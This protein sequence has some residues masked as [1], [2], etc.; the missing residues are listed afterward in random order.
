MNNVEILIP[1]TFF[2]MIGFI[3]WAIARTRQSRHAAEMQAQFHQKMLDRFSSS[4]DFIAFIQSAEGGRYID[5]LTR[6]PVSN[7]LTKTLSAVRTGIIIAFLAGG[8]V[9]VGAI[10]GASDGRDLMLFGLLG[11]FLGA[12]FLVS[13]WASHRLSRSWGLEPSGNGNP[14]GV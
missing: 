10:S 11:L 7:P 3:V 14:A 6:T 1:I 9:A 13:A 8:L 2:V 4:Q 12:G 5:S